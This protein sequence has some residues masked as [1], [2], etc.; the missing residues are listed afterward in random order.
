[1]SLAG[2]DKDWRGGTVEGVGA[3]PLRAVVGHRP[4]QRGLHH[5]RFPRIHP[6]RPTPRVQEA[7]ASQ[8]LPLP[9]WPCL[10]QPTF[11]SGVE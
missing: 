2:C 1:M 4:G 9:P 3:E 10:H 5:G 6:P 8:D 11:P 7:A